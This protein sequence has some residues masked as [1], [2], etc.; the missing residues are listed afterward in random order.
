MHTGPTRIGG[1][2]GSSTRQRMA[3]TLPQAGQVIRY[4]YLWWNGPRFNW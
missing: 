2:Y 3:V 4:A 1:P